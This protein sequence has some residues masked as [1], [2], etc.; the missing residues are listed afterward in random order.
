[1]WLA[2]EL[3][4]SESITGLVAMAGYLPATLLSLWSGL[5]AD[6]KNRRTIL[7]GADLARTIIVLFIPLAFF[8]GVLSP[9]LLAV[10]AFAL[11]IAATFFNPARD[12]MIPQI[13]PADGLLR[14]NSLIQT[15]D[16]QGRS[17]R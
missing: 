8:T 17:H 12:A 3:T 16:Y 5:L 9:W 2:L 15:Y 4:G 6:R 13:V 10:N 14:A 7:L 1:M 11:A